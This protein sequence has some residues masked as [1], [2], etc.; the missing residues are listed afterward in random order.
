MFQSGGLGL[1]QRKLLSLFVRGIGII[2]VFPFASLFIVTGN[3]GLNLS[4]ESY[5]YLF[6]CLKNPVIIHHEKL[7]L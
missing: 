7:A 3:L 6:L 2:S 1:G 4:L 5:C